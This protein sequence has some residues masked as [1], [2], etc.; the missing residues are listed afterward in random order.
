MSRKSERV[1][2]EMKI[3]KYRASRVFE[4][5]SARQLKARKP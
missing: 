2:F 4:L 5:R 1:D 3:M